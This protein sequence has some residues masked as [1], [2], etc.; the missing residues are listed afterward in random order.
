MG[1]DSDCECR[2]GFVGCSQ[3]TK[4]VTVSAERALLAVVKLQLN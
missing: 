2:E 4:T 3:L 1:K